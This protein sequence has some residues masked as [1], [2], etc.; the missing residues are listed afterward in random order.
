MKA[1]RGKFDVILSTL[2]GDHDM[3]PF[4]KLLA[5][6]GTYVVVGAINDMTHPLNL[7]A[8]ISRRK[9]IA[10]SNIGGLKETQEMLDFAGEH[11]ITAD[12]ELISADY[13]NEAYK[14]V[15]ASDVQFRFVID[16]ATIP[17]A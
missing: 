13:V 17:A 3:N 12:I 5:F 10:G 11:G 1:W 4:I 14:R 16:T 2:P 9:S 15:V 6:E 7:P 8:L